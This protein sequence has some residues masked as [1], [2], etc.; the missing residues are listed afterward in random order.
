MNAALRLVAVLIC[1]ALCSCRSIRLDVTPA[2]AKPAPL[3][4][5]YDRRAPGYGIVLKGAAQDF[6]PTLGRWER[7]Y[8]LRVDSKQ[9]LFNMIQATMTPAEVARLRCDPAVKFIE[10]NGVVLIGAIVRSPPNNWL[11][12]TAMGKMPRHDRQR[13]AAEPGR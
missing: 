13:A 10:H 4:G 7:E 6:W 8:S 3:E 5:K 2:C 1:I 12:R 9:Y 11:Q